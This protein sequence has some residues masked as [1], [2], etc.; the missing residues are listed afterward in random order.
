M[1]N[2]ISISILLIGLLISSSSCNEMS[3]HMK[4][5]EDGSGEIIFNM[6]I[7]GDMLEMIAMMMAQEA[8][9]ESKE[10][11]SIS[12][13]FSQV[14]DTTIVF[15]DFVP[16]SLRFGISEPDFW[17]NWTMSFESDTIQKS[18]KMNMQLSFDSISQMHQ[19]MSDLSVL[20][21]DENDLNPITPS[22][23]TGMIDTS[24]NW[25]PGHIY[26]KAAKL[27]EGFS[28]EDLMNEMGA[29]SEQIMG[30]M[31]MFLGELT[32]ELTV[33]VPGNIVECVCPFGT[34]SGNTATMQYKIIDIFRDIES[35]NKDTHIYYE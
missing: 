4:F 28:Q 33:E 15:Y 16:D 26:W 9:N 27:P 1:K 7:G 20:T 6:G 31:Q 24:F 35:F 22:Q 21:I 25:E 17:K 19:A 32:F 5:N 34:F 3:Q 8:G 30:M 13:L 18:A 11:F 29:D 10:D 14:P 23:L 2:L 12:Q